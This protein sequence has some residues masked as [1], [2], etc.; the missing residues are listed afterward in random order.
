MVIPANESTQTSSTEYDVIILG[1]AFSGSS[2]ALLIKRARPATRILIVEKSEIFDR[3]V[4]ESTSEVA[5]CFLTRVLGL[6]N[7]LACHHFQKHGL[8][9]WFT[10]AD[11]TCAGE[12]T[13][14]GPFAQARLPTFQLDRSK[15]DQHLLETAVAEGCELLRPA[16][17]KSFE[18]GGAGNNTVTLKVDGITRTLRAGW[19]ADASGRAAL[20]ARSRGLWRPL[21]EHPVHSM[22]VRFSNVRCL[23][24]HES[25]TLVPAIDECRTSSARGSSTNHLMGRG[26][27][28]WIIPLSNG[29][30]SAGVTWDERLFSPPGEGP[31]GQRVKQHLLGHPVGRLMFENAEP[32][33]NDARIYKDLPYHATQVAGDGWMLAGD[34][35]GFMDPLYSQGLDYCAHS[36]YAGHKILLRALDGEC[37]KDSIAT[38]NREFGESYHRWFNGIYRNKYQYLG[39]A[40]LMHAAFLLDVGAYFLGPARLVYTATD[41]EFSKMPYNGRPGSFFAWLMATYNARFEVIARKKIA[42][43]SYGMNNLRQRYFIRKPFEPSPKSLYH[44]FKGLRMWLK[45]EMQHAFVRPDPAMPEPELMPARNSNSEAVV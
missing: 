43:G 30:Y 1:G 41:A 6:S 4:G 44:F 32:A 9:M 39:D 36:V 27:W 15:L 24:G 19:I 17:I 22:W 38:H 35:A 31:V 25:R 29:D 2:L 20:I 42:R 23:D 16:T 28:S 7:Y 5:G 11:N 3:K 34:A 45:L 14:V 21:P 10:E 8:R 12:C 13:E 26:W 40:D 37:V 33:E 18:L